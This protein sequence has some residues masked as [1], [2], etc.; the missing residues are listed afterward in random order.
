MAEEEHEGPP[1]FAEMGVPRLVEVRRKPSSN[2][3]VAGHLASGA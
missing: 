2:Y 3:D 1:D